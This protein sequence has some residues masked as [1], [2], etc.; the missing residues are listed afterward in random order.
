MYWEHEFPT[1]EK[2]YKIDNDQKLKDT[3]RQIYDAGYTDSLI[4]QD[5][6][7]GND[8]FMRVLT[9]FSGKDKKVKMMCLGHV[10][11]EEH[12]PHGSGN[13]A[14]II[15]EPQEELMTKVK[16]LLETIGYVGF[17]NFDIKYDVR[18]NRYKFFEINTRQGRSNYYVTGS[19][20]NVARYFVEEFVY[21]KEIPFE[22]AKE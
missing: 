5:T 12:T 18:D 13:H 10:L 17:S 7:P 4:I 3:I 21:N 22:I 20:F 8:E 6:I 19:G 1:Q 9:C 16:N 11:L 15:T 14:V 2:V